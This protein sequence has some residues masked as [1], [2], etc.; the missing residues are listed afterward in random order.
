MSDISLSQSMRNKYQDEK[1]N[2]KDVATVDMHVH[3]HVCTCVCTYV[4]TLSSQILG[5][6]LC[7]ILQHCKYRESTNI[8]TYTYICMN[9]QIRTYVCT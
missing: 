7:N 3:T 8:H 5:S 2:D 4:C 1:N 6:Q 9:L